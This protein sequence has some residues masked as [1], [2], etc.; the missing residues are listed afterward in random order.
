[1]QQAFRCF[2]V[3]LSLK[4]FIQNYAV[5]I[6]STPQPEFPAFDVHG[7]FVQM[8]DVAGQWLSA[9]HSAR[10]GW[11]KFRNPSADGLV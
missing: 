9:A 8:P 7:N 6:N 1:M 10:D 3:A 5:L 11:A 2:L 4:D